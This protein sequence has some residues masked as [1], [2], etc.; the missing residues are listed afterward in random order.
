MYFENHRKKRLVLCAV[1]T[2]AA[3]GFSGKAARASTDNYVEIQIGAG[4]L[5]TI[6]HEQFTGNSDFCPQ[7]IPCPSAPQSQCVVDHLDIG[8]AG[9]WT[10]EAASSNLAINSFTTIQ[11]Q[12]VI[13][14]QSITAQVKT[15]ACANTPGCTTLTAYPLSLSYE[16]YVNAEGGLCIRSHGFPGMPGGAAPPE[17]NLCLGLNGDDILA[18]SG[19]TNATLSGA[20]ASLSADGS[21]IAARLEYGR[22][23][24]AYDTARINAWQTFAGGTLDA[25]GA[26]GDWS[27]L[28]HRTLI[29]AGLQQRVSD[30]IASVSGFDLTSGMA[31]SWTP[32]GAAG[33]ETT[34]SFDASISNTPCPNTI[35]ADVSLYALI[36]M[37]AAHDGLH[38]VGSIDWG[39]DEVDTAL[40]GLAL[41][42]PVGA[43]V[44]ATIGSAI[45]V[46][47]A[48]YIAECDPTDDTTFTCDQK[49]NPK[50][51]SISPGQT[52]TFN[53]S[54]VFGSTHGLTMSGPIAL[55]TPKPLTSS[56]EVTPLG[57]GMHGNCGKDKKCEYTGAL[58]VYGTAR[59]C[60]VQFSGNSLYEIDPP[61]DYG[62]PAQF[63]IIL[64]GDLTPAQKAQYQAAPELTATV[65]T[66]LGVHAYAIPPVALLSD[67]SEDLACGVMKAEAKFHCLYVREFPWQ[68]IFW[69]WWPDEQI[70]NLHQIGVSVLDRN[71]S[72]LDYGMVQQLGIDVVRDRSGYVLS[73]TIR[74][75]AHLGMGGE[76]AV[77]QTLA[78]AV[79]VPR[80]TQISDD[81]RLIATLLPSGYSGVV[82]L[83][84]TV[85]AQAVGGSFQLDISRE[86]LQAAIG[87]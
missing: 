85:P 84:R 48:S 26:A 25:S 20:A 51:F 70:D 38:S 12:K 24:A 87:R 78:L 11:A 5:S 79:F 55:S 39:L 7:I 60:D 30:G 27:V 3:V 71:R 17:T 15:L 54:G 43:I 77:A 52:A 59:L 34:L 14:T 61:A 10:R 50:M 37:N 83:D 19:L 1:I 2:G 69:R 57:F 62:L 28:V 44:L 36:G 74:G 8:S 41:G 47:V 32:L 56:V 63:E 45:S 75:V 67:Q 29:L 81:G 13:Y 66:A 40:C 58:S 4:V 82:A 31:V 72:F 76:D 23:Q 46:D 68:R 16:L 22:G 86:Q 35:G 33:A 21:R 64:P 6:A 49:T 65:W 42:G 53:L 73:V 18:A 80:G 9:S